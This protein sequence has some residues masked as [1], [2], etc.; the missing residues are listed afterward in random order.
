M[1]TP[2]PFADTPGGDPFAGDPDPSTLGEGN[3]PETPDEQPAS[4]PGSTPPP[5]TPAE[6]TP[7]PEEQPA[8]APPPPP[9]PPAEEPPAPAG[10]DGAAAAAA[11]GADG[12]GDDDNGDDAA[13]EKGTKSPTRPYVIFVHVGEDDGVQRWEQQK[14]TIEARNNA[15]A[16]QLAYEALGAP[17]TV[18]LSVIPEGKWQPVTVE[19]EEV[20]TKRTLKITA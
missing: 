4:V 20:V 5:E 19:P 14:K 10:A 11:A 16:R 3:A 12:N 6:P 2:D 15:H 8:Q 9:E 13:A 17:P 18:R 1:E 7:T